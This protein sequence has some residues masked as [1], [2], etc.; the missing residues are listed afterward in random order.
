MT[1]VGVRELKARASEIL[2]QVEEGGEPIEIT[3]RGKVVA[4]LVPAE[5]P[6]PTRE[7]LDAIW[8]RRERLADEISKYWPEGVTAVDAVREQRRF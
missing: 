1:A 2:R 6:R 4:R 8:A 5:R 7:E 3:K